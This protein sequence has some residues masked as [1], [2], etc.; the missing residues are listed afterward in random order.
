MINYSEFFLMLE[1]V[2]LEKEFEQLNGKYHHNKFAPKIIS[3]INEILLL[4]GKDA[5]LRLI[6]LKVKYENYTG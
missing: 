5:D 1:L 2:L 3:K 4:Q 6:D